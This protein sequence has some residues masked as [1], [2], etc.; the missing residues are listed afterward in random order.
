MDDGDSEHDIDDIPYVSIIFAKRDGAMD[1][2]RV[3][4]NNGQTKRV[5]SQYRFVR[6]LTPY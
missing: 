2:W 3:G 5:I 4:R 1:G 6:C